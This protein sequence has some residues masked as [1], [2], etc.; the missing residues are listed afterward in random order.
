MPKDNPI[1]EIIRESFQNRF[2]V[3]WNGNLTYVPKQTMIHAE[4][5]WSGKEAGGASIWDKILVTWS[6]SIKIFCSWSYSSILHRFKLNITHLQIVSN[7]FFSPT[8]P[9]TLIP[10]YRYWYIEILSICA[11]LRSLCLIFPCFFLAL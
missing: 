9:D 8:E 2:D 3:T 7:K 5:I 1:G 11:Y 6:L 4:M 10:W